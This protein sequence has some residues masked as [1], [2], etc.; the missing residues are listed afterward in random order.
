M[1]KRLLILSLTGLL[2]A[3]VP[4][5]SQASTLE[6]AAVEQTD[7]KIEISVE[8]QTV[9]VNGAQGEELI[10]VSLT[11]RQ[12]LKAKIERPAQRIDLNLPKGCYILKVGK[13]VRKIQVR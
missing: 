5:V 8:G 11:G 1:V 13:V 3:S 10:V 2:L 7:E 4:V 9:Y 6:F 12:V